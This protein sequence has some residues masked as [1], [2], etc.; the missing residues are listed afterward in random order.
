MDK[1]GQDG[2]AA[3]LRERVLARRLSVRGR[4]IID[5]QGA[6]L[7]ADEVEP[8]ETTSADAANEVMQRWGVVL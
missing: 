8:D 4:S 7:L 3:F 1:D 6:M 2:F 5:D